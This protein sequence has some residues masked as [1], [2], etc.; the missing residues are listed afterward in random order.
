MTETAQAVGLPAS[1]KVLCAVYALTAI[2]AFAA[3]WSQNLAYADAP[4]L[5]SAFGR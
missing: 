4:N 1:S 3:T 5:I 2:G